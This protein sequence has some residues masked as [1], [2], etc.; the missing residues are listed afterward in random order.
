[1]KKL[2]LKILLCLLLVLLIGS[3]L[4]ICFSPYENR[5]NQFDFTAD[6]GKAHR[7]FAVYLL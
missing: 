4:F 5:P 2:L 6:G 7:T 3:N 1:M